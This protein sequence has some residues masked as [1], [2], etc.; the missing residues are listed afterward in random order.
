MF[1]NCAFTSFT[2]QDMS[3]FVRLTNEFIVAEQSILISVIK[4]H[5]W[6][7][8][9]F[10]VSGIFINRLFSLKCCVFFIHV[11]SIKRTSIEA[12]SYLLAGPFHLALNIDFMGGRKRFTGLRGNT[13]LVELTALMFQNARLVPTLHSGFRYNLV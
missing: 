12:T 9:Y 5:N 1:A 8:S 10:C 11:V 7:F 3:G 4:C 2:H 6:P 13:N